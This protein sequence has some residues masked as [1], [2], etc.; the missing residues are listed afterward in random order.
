MKKTINI[1]TAGRMPAVRIAAILAV[2]VGL[3]CASASL[4][5]EAYCATV[6]IQIEQ[7]LTLERQA[8]DA[9]MKINNGLDGIDLTDVQVE[10]FITDES[11]S[12]ITVATTDEYAANINTND[13]KFFQQDPSLTNI[14]RLPAGTVVG[15][16]SAEINWLLIPAV[17]ASDDNP[18]G[19]M[20]YV[21]ATLTY[22]LQE[23]TQT[24]EVAPDYIF[25]KP[26]P[27]LELDYFLPKYVYGDNP[28]SPE[29]EPEIPFPLGLRIKNNG[30]GAANKVQIESG[31]PEIIENESGLL[32]GFSIQSSSVNGEPVSPSLRM[33]YGSIESFGSKM[34][35]WEMKASLAGLFTNFTAD[36]SHSDELGGAMTSLIN[37]TNVH[38]HIHIKDV[39]VDLQDRDRVV[40]FLTPG[41]VYESE[42]DEISASPLDGTLAPIS[43]LNHEFSFSIT[44]AAL[45]YVYA[46]IASPF[47][48]NTDDYSIK[49]VVRSDGKVM[50]ES[51]VW[52]SKEGP[53]HVI[54]EVWHHYF[55]LFD[56]N[57]SE[58]TY[59]VELMDI[60]EV[61]NP[62]VIQYIAPQTVNPG[63]NIG[64]IVVASDDG[65]APQLSV[66]NLPSGATFTQDTNSTDLAYGEFDWTPTENQSGVYQVKFI[67][68]DGELFSHRLAVLTVTGDVL[69]PAS[70]YPDWWLSRG[71]IDLDATVTN[72]F[73]A[74]NQ[75]QLKHVATMAWDEF[76]LLPG[77]ADIQPFDFAVESN[78]YAAVNVGQLK[79]TVAPF[80]DRIG[81]T[82]NYPW[83]GSSNDTDYAIANIGQVKNLFSFEPLKDSDTDGMPD[84]WE[85]NY[86]NSATAMP[87]DGNPD[88]DDHSN[89][90]EYLHGT[91]PNEQD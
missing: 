57:G 26:M 19:K 36:I 23:E 64:F 17:G 79:S 65:G 90:Y 10:I 39:V 55:N 1:F 89:L 43:G 62:P 66:G 7:E 69:P 71:I 68:S 70:N 18:Q 6:E 12:N 85:S 81:M 77:G 20:Y 72:D 48:A 2:G 25:V 5:G 73:S 9:R 45:D 58:Y 4:A 38:T 88:G 54:G 16:Q 75:G 29:I 61:N 27:Y 3:F 50:H 41:I 60:S 63:G 42:G 32:I 49:R 30:F 56:V 46:T 44:N 51:N 91:N 11:G 53:P 21:G 86:T 8:F 31:Q 24:I 59:A 47:G 76:N 78:N 37:P 35:Y 74:V 80:Y 14:D 33:D 13:A 22:T 28:T 15:G 84:W 82:N 52:F 34:G 83:S 67:A 40:D 87:P